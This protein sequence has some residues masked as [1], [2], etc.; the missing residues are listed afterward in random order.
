MVSD[1]LRDMGTY[2]EA[3]RTSFW[4]DAAWPAH[5]VGAT[6]LTTYTF[7]AVFFETVLLQMLLAGGAGPVAVFVDE[8]SGYQSALAAGPA[9]RSA[10]RD[11]HLIP[12]DAG[13]WVFH[14]KV[15]LF[16]GGSGTALVG[17]GNLTRSGCGGNLEAFYRLTGAMEP[18]ALAEISDFFRALLADPRS[19]C[20]EQEKRYLAAQLPVPRAASPGGP[21]F[22]HSQGSTGLA[23]QLSKELAITELDRATLAAPFHDDTGATSKRLIALTE[24]SE[25]EMA[26]GPSVPPAN[27]GTGTTGTLSDENERPLH[28]KLLAAAS[29]EASLLVLGSANLTSAAWEPGRNVEAVVLH[30]ALDPT[31]HGDFLDAAVFMPCAWNGEPRKHAGDANGLPSLPIFAAELTGDIL[32]VLLPPSIQEPTIRVSCMDQ[33]IEIVFSDSSGEGTWSGYARE[34][35]NG[36]L[37]VTVSAVGYAASRRFVSRLHRLEASDER[38]RMKSRLDRL[39][40]DGVDDGMRVEMLLILGEAVA[41]YAEA[42]G[43]GAFEEGEKK[44]ATAAGRAKAGSGKKEQP[45]ETDMG[46]DDVE[47]FL[48]GVPPARTTSRQEIDRWRRFVIRLTRSSSASMPRTTGSPRWHPA[49]ADIGASSAV[50]D[51]D[52]DQVVD[53][54]QQETLSGPSEQALESADDIEEL[55]PKIAEWNLERAALLHEVVGRS[56]EG[57]AQDRPAD[58]A[59]LC[60][61]LLEWQC[62]GWGALDWPHLEGG[63]LV[64]LQEDQQAMAR[65]ALRLALYA[66]T[67]VLRHEPDSDKVLDQA[68]LVWLGTG[69][70]E[71]LDDSPAGEDAAEQ[72]EVED[73]V[74]ALLDV[75]RTRATRGELARQSLRPL[76]QLERAG[77]RLLEAE[78]GE[79]KTTAQAEVFAARALLCSFDFYDEGSAREVR[80]AWQIWTRARWRGLP[81]G[82]LAR[83]RVVGPEPRVCP[84]CYAELSASLRL[85]L[86]ADPGRVGKCTSLGCGALL[87]HGDVDV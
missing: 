64:E 49:F 12:F 22:L 68:R 57:L 69:E 86:E 52:A 74:E 34:L 84:A 75:L 14:P 30:Q 8:G 72:P 71:S 82:E 45:P 46:I 44:K 73:G 13:D 77:R 70:F 81:G 62:M 2:T 35:P 41:T 26:S 58:R 5:N 40:G 33:E 20:S 83:L 21:Q 65:E 80:S 1:R 9:L 47:E 19:R 60:E 55:L 78:D 79:Q 87:V 7:D 36:I 6:F 53:G 38:A 32:G 61:R 24:S 31:V 66:A 27:A 85:W 4:L 54:S 56:L 3:E 63:L 16:A 29:D 17:S 42:L 59:T 76:W 43:R 51:E 15:H 10:A 11:Y 67:T 25:V 28:A 23:D 50:E 39:R 48:L 37:T 18:R